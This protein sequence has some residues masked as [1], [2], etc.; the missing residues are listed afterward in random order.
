MIPKLILCTEPHSLPHSKGM[1]FGS[2]L[3]SSLTEHSSW[4]FVRVLSLMGQKDPFLLLHNSF[5]RKVRF[6]RVKNYESRDSATPG[7]LTSRPL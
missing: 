7:T 4:Q 5:P 2:H 3:N 6:S 1:S